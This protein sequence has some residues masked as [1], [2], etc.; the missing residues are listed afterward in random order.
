MRQDL[1]TIEPHDPGWAHSFHAQKEALEGALRSWLVRPVE[2]VLV[3]MLRGKA[4]VEVGTHT[5]HLDEGHALWLP[6]GVYNRIRTAHNGIVVPVGDLP[7][8]YPITISDIAPLPIPASRAPEMLYR[9]AASYT[10]L[11]PYP[12]DSEHTADLAPR[13]CPGAGADAPSPRSNPPNPIDRILTSDPAGRRTIRD[14]SADLDIPAD[15]LARWFHRRTGHPYRKWQL[16]RRMTLAR[17]LL[18]QPAQTP[19]RVARELGYS[20]LSAFTR[21]FTRHHR[22]SPTAFQ[23]TYRHITHFTLDQDL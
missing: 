8:R 15:K 22:Q 10:Y 20:E 14:W 3:W 23:N 19:T 13:R 2:H 1:I 5:L 12:H 16:N 9:S 18:I 11:R 7:A 17:S 21:A 6:A 4:Q